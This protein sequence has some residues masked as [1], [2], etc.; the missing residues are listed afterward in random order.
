MATKT[1][2]R[3]LSDQ[4]MRERS[5]MFPARQGSVMTA[6]GQSAELLHFLRQKEGGKY[7]DLIDID[8]YYASTFEGDIVEEIGVNM[9]RDGVDR[10]TTLAYLT[11]AEQWN[12]YGEKAMTKRREMETMGKIYAAKGHIEPLNK[13]PSR[14]TTFTVSDKPY[15]NQVSNVPKDI[16]E[17]KAKIIEKARE[18]KDA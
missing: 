8:P 3:T 2:K 17:A 7:L 16:K 1:S 6:Q 9:Q 4:E 10:Y 13:R 15:F 11:T 5:K 18:E 12:V 14:D